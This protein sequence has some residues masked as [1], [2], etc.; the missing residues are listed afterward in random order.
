LEEN[1]ESTARSIGTRVS[2]GLQGKAN[3]AMQANAEFREEEGRTV[4]EITGEVRK[5]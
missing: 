1:C 3:H 2:G 5:M 4:C